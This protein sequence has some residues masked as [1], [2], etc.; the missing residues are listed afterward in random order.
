MSVLHLNHKNKVF[1]CSENLPYNSSLTEVFIYHRINQ[2]MWITG[3]DCRGLAQLLWKQPCLLSFRYLYWNTKTLLV[4]NPAA[5]SFLS[6]ERRAGGM[7]SGPDSHSQKVRRCSLGSS[8]PADFSHYLRSTKLFLSHCNSQPPAWVTSGSRLHPCATM[9]TK[10][11]RSSVDV[12]LSQIPYSQQQS[13]KGSSSSWTVS[14]VK[15]HCLR[16]DCE[17]KRIYL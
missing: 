8:P 4:T 9:Q 11:P 15:A 14:A 17:L 6:C 3:D 7:A 5:A 12:Q 10:Q 1:W 13:H 2:V 16:D